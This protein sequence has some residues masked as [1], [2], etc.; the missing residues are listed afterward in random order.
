VAT[1]QAVVAGAADEAVIALTPEQPVVSV[2][3]GQPVI[4]AAAMQPITPAVAFEL[5]VTA[6]AVKP[7]TPAVP[8]QLIIGR[9]TGS[10]SHVTTGFPA[11]LGHGS[12][13]TRVTRPTLKALP[14]E[15]HPRHSAWPQSGMKVRHPNHETKYCP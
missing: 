1:L 7:I 6:L 2:I 5:V 15:R 14:G 13:P 4:A 3:A 8:N 9:A 10:P 12:S 11:V